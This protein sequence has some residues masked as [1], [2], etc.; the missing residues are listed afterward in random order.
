[1]KKKYQSGSIVAGVAELIRALLAWLGLLRFA[2]YLKH[3][4]KSEGAR[5]SVNETTWV[6]SQH[7]HE[8]NYWL[9]VF[10]DEIPDGQSA[11]SFYKSHYH[12]LNLSMFDGLNVDCTGLTVAD[13]GSGPFGSLPLI[14]DSKIFGVDP[15]T[16][17]YISN[18]P[19]Q[20][21]LSRI[22]ARAEQLP[23]DDG[24]FDRV[25]CVNALDH[26]KD[27]YAS[28]NEMIRVLKPGG[29]LALAVDV[30][31]TPEHPISLRAEDLDLA[32]LHQFSVVE[33]RCS[34]DVPSSWPDSM[35]VPVYVFQG[36]VKT[37]E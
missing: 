25:Y 12:P 20:E 2:V 16:S 3:L 36:L 14:T 24:F 37:G 9:E 26:F 5:R 19:E 31:P 4:L 17:D 35:N 33:R 22:D 21:T 27:P 10:P 23:F 13:I 7:N 28:I 1:V 18:F 15:L 32:L 8:L 29:Y 30:G 11:E 6:T 34:P